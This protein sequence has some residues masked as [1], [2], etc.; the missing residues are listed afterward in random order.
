MGIVLAISKKDTGTFQKFFEE[1]FPRLVLFADKY[2][3]NQD[4]AADIAQECFIRLWYS[5]IEFESEEKIR[6]F[7]YTTA[8]NLSL[9]HIK[10]ARVAGL[11]LKRETEQEEVFMYDNVMEEE[12]YQLVHKAID[13]L[14]LQSKK[15][16]LLSLQGYSNQE[17]AD[18]MDVSV[19][20]VRTLKQNA[21]RK[22]KGLLKEHFYVVAI[23]MK[24]RLF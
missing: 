10:H 5:D 18:Q 13:H 14:A 2:L 7:L 24:M 12:T 19:N 1:N 3:D 22:L 6:G 21:Y 8:R 17:I 15:I 4:I 16:I 20:T 23:L 11:Y 9:N